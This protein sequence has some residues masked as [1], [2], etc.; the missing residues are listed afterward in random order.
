MTWPH[1][2]RAFEHGVEFTVPSTIQHAP[3]GPLRSQVH[4]RMTL[5]ARMGARTPLMTA[6]PPRH[7][8][9]RYGTRW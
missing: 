5:Q 1:R 2:T 4:D 6:G 7:L 8:R 9:T 3:P